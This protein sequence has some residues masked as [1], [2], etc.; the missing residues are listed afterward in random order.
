MRAPSIKDVAKASGVSYKT[1]SRVINDEGGASPATRERI[2]AA[3][4]DLGYRPHHGARSLRRGRTETLRLIAHRRDQG[5]L[6]TNPF[7]DDVIGGVVDTAARLGYAVL[8]ELIDQHPGTEPVSPG[9]HERRVDGNILLDSRLPEPL[10]TPILRDAGAPAVVLANRDVD[11]ALGWIDA[12]FR[13]GGERLVSYLLDLGHRRIAHLADDPSLRSSVARR[14]GYERALVARGIPPDPALVELGGQYREDGDAATER[15]LVRCPDMT[16]IFAVN[17]L[18]AFGAI[19]CLRRHGRRVPEDVS[20]TGFDDI[21]LA[22]WADP[23]LTT[24]HIPWYEM[25]AAAAEL[26]VGAAEGTREFPAGLEFPVELCLRGP[27]AAAG[28]DGGSL[29]RD[30]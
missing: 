17:D 25:A 21:A 12:D 15:L 29:P 11:P 7:M 3:I 22:R 2:R 18:S 26:L 28:P 1:V 5:R 24:V 27:T 19:D 8:V 10:L 6:L 20:V 30:W 9:F 13:G 16:A 14:A 4:A 23:P